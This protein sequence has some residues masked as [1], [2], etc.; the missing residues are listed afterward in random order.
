MVDAFSIRPPRLLDAF[1]CN[2]LHSSKMGKLV[3]WKGFGFSKSETDVIA[4]A[5]AGGPSLPSGGAWAVTAIRGRVGLSSVDV[6]R[7]MPGKGGLANPWEGGRG[8]EEVNGRVGGIRR[9]L[10]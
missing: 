10:R 2:L 7:P 4:T 3:C 6:N 1:C 9:E 5:W 8:S